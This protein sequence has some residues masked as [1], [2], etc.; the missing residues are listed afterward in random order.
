M[1]DHEKCEPRRMKNW[2]E[3]SIEEKLERLRDQ[4]NGLK[5]SVRACL[6]DIEVLKEHEHLADGKPALKLNNRA[7]FDSYPERANEYF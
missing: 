2:N 4:I 3:C 5:P 6:L 1:S 7:I